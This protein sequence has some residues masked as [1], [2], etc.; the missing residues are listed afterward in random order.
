MARLSNTHFERAPD[1]VAP[2]KLD[3]DRVDAILM[4]DEANSILV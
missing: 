1:Y 4:G 2:I 3:I